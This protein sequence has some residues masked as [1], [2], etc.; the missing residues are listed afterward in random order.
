M[1]LQPYFSI[2]VDMTITC[3]N[4]GADLEC[5]EIDYVQ[6]NAKVIVTP[7]KC[8]LGEFVNGQDKS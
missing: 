7:C 3:E 4:C 2:D 6:E 8:L 1:V 5:V